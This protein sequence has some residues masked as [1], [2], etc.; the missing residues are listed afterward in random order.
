MS[1]P[2]YTVDPSGTARPYEARAAVPTT[3]SGPQSSTAVSNEVRTPPRPIKDITPSSVPASP[4]VSAPEFGATRLAP[5]VGRA[6]R[7]L[8]SPV[9]AAVQGALYAGDVNT[10]QP[11]VAKDREAIV[12]EGDLEKLAS[13][14]AQ[15]KVLK[16]RIAGEF[17]DIGGKLDDVKQQKETATNE[18]RGLGGILAIRRDPTGTVAQKREELQGQITK[19]EE[20]QRDLE[21]EYAVS[22]K[23]SGIDRVTSKDQIANPAM[24]T[25]IATQ[26]PAARADAVV[27][28]PRKSFEGSPQAIANEIEGLGVPN[29]KKNAIR[30]QWASENN[31]ELPAPSKTTTSNA[32]AASGSSAAP[33]DD[34]APRDGAGTTSRSRGADDP[35][36]NRLLAQEALGSRLLASNVRNTKPVNTVEEEARLGKIG[37]DAYLKAQGMPTSADSMKQRI[38]KLTNEATQARKDRDV[39]RWMAVAQGFFAMGAG[40]SRYALQNFATGLGIGT[41]EFKNVEKDYRKGV[42]LRADRTDLLGEAARLEARNDYAGARIRVKDA[43][44]VNEDI[45]KTNIEIGKALSISANTAM[46]VLDARRERAEYQRDVLGQRGT[47]FNERMEA[48][49]QEVDERTARQTRVDAENKFQKRAALLELQMANIA[50]QRDVYVN[51]QV[52]PK[53][54]GMVSK[55]NNPKTSDKDKAEIAADPAYIAHIKKLT[56]FD[57]REQEVGDRQI[58]LYGNESGGASG[59]TLKGVRPGQ[60]G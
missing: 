32:P 28:S 20:Q 12:A 39:D 30:Y 37:E 58:D 52:L 35:A 19:L 2:D 16:A 25:G 10:D 11:S 5:A 38:D 36:M 8:V 26:T 33:S 23:A 31:A 17:D 49:R 6:A 1:R 60:G 45:K 53:V 44:K 24:K 13:F 18:L 29:D 59:F 47:E 34:V 4:T 15:Q 46:G 9:G 54:T 56:E 14:D 55:F 7:A 43:D 50:K 57:R 40:T 51:K 3:V 21:R 42:Q 48:R 27:Q 41:T 22:A